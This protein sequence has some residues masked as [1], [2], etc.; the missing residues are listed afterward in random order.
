MIISDS[1]IKN[2][3]PHEPTDEDI[4]EAKKLENGFWLTVCY[5]HCEK[6]IYRGKKRFFAGVNCQSLYFVQLLKQNEMI[7]QGSLL[8]DILKAARP[9]TAM[10]AGIAIGEGCGHEAQSNKRLDDE[11]RKIDKENK[12]ES[13]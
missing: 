10:E 7:I 12:N 1:D 3:K 5:K 4:A 9:L 13:L 2:F 8:T 11:R 6:C